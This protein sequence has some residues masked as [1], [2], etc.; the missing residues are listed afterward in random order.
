MEFPSIVLERT[1]SVAKLL[2]K[3][4]PLNILDIAAMRELSVALESLRQDQS[5]KVVVLSA[6]G[7]AFSV[8][9]DISDHTADKVDA[10]MT[11]LHEVFEGLWALEQPTVAIVKGAA[12]GGGME[13]AIACDFIIASEG[14]QFGQP[15]IKV[16]VF[17]PIACLLLPRLLPWPRA[18][19]LILTGESIS[20]QEAY[21]LGLVN[22]V[23]PAENLAAEAEAFVSKLASLSGPVLKLAK[24]AARIGLG[25]GRDPGS[26]KILAELDRL[27]LDE[28]MKLED[29]HEGLRA[30]MDKRNPAWQ[31][32]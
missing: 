11:V 16:G 6:E 5:S 8:G 29:A 10:M 26:S 18:L 32:R 21:R 2:L 12:L 13:L 23:V 14:A 1:H 31:D 3:R 22:R 17:P 15:E 4:P 7:K 25:Q 20:A 19:E 9:V 28:L 24:R 27:Y 30:F